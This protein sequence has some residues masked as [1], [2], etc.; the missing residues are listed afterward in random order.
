MQKRPHHLVVMGIS[1][2]G[3]TTLGALLSG[4][5]GWRFVEGDTLHPHA[6]V[7]KMSGGR[8]LNDDDRRPWLSRI[9]AAIAES[10]R[11]VII[12]SSPVRR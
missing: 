12:A 7:D 4:R 10:M 2:S 1:G 11:R 9:A 6:N 5:L 3:K 8:P